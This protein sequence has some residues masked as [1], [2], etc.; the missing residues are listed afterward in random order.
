MSKH[1]EKEK[2]CLEEIQDNIFASNP[3]SGKTFRTA[4]D[5]EFENEYV[6]FINRLERTHYF[7]MSKYDCFLFETLLRSASP[8]PELSQF[9]DFITKDGFIEHFQITSSITTKKGA[10][11]EK[12]INI[13]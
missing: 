9:P 11:H 6:L 1:G 5:E 2:K 4:T 8:N 7:G 13:F 3:F 10:T 12:N